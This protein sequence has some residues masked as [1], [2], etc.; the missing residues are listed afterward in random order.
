M[1]AVH[2]TSGLRFRSKGLGLGMLIV[3]EEEVVVVVV[4]AAAAAAA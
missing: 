3:L 1:G 2:K 4:A